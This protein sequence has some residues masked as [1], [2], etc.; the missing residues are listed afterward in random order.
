MTLSLL[1]GAIVALHAYL[2][3]NIATKLDE[4]DA[5]FGDGIVLDDIKSWYLGNIPTAVPEYPSIWLD[6]VR[7]TPKR[8]LEKGKI[9]VDYRIDIFILI[10]CTDEQERFKRLDRYAM[11]IMELMESNTLTYRYQWMGDVVKSSEYGINGEWLQGYKLPLQLS[12]KE[13]F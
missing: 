1:E 4:I 6:G 10:G 12:R 5:R 2:A 9:D 11:A 3:A 7:F 8:N 13:S